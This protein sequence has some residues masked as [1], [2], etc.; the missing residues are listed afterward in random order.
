MQAAESDRHSVELSQV[1]VKGKEKERQVA[2]LERQCDILKMDIQ[3][4]RQEIARS[5]CVC[6]CVW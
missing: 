3:G 2:S 4:C 1:Q 5:V 6:V